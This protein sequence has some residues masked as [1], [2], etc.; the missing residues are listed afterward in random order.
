MIYVANPST[1]R[2]RAAMS[3]G[4]IGCITTPR[5]GNRVPEG[6]WWC[7]DNGV[8]GK[9]YPGDARWLSWLSSRTADPDRCLFV[10]APDV[11]GDAWATLARSVPFLPVIRELGYPAGF[12]AQNGTDET[13]IPWDDL[14]CLFI[15]GD[16]DY[17]LGEHAAELVNAARSHAKWV[18]M[19]RVNSRKR[20]E[21]AASIGCDS[22]DGTFLAFGPD[23][24]LD[25]LLSWSRPRVL[26]HSWRRHRNGEPCGAC[27]D[28]WE[29][30]TA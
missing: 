10:T 15:G 1:P 9:G 27:P 2:V 28:P 26:D 19:G 22:A 20:F 18:H 25:E 29:E 21:Y 14:D 3:A 23:V 16:D 5:Q 6:S 30:W 24:N 13:G 17:K 12:V 11:V 8:F 7:A 4:L